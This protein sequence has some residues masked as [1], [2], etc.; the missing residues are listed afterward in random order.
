MAK[1]LI[2][3][4][5][6]GSDKHVI[7]TWQYSSEIKTKVQEWESGGGEYVHWDTEVSGAIPDCDPDTP[8]VD[9][10]DYA[11]KR[12]CGYKIESDPLYIEYQGC[13]KDGDDPGTSEAIW[14]TVRDAIKTKYP[15][16]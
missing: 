10:R 15:K 9:S 5:I 16:P 11:E 3:L 6:D 7:G 12:E 2:I 8:W 1:Y 14:T 4:K 13:V